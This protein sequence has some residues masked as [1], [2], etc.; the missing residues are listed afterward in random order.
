MPVRLALEPDPRAPLGAS[1]CTQGLRFGVWAPSATRVELCL[2]DPE[3]TEEIARADLHRARHGR[4]CGLWPQGQAGQV[5]GLRAHGPW[6]PAR[7]QRF[8]PNKLLLDPYAREVVGDYRGDPA[9]NGHRADDPLAPDLRDNARIAL[10][11]RA[12][13]DPPAAARPA[14]RADDEVV[15]YEVHVKAATH[16]LAGVPPALRGTYAGLAHPAFVEHLRHLG[17]TTLSLL[18]VAHRVDESRLLSLGL[19]NHWGYNPIAF[20]A[21]ERRYWSGRPGTTPTSE[22]REMVRSLH[23]AGLEVVLDVVFNHTGETDEFGPTLSLRGLGNAESYHL[24]P[25]DPARYENWTG[26]GHALRLD[27]PQGVQ[28]VVDALRHW[29]EV[30]GVDGFRFDLATT[31]A[32]DARGFA[33]NAGLFAAMQADPVLRSVRWIAEPWDIGPGGYRLGQFP[34]GW[35]EWNDRY[36]DTVRAYWLTGGATRGALAQVLAGSDGS[37][38]ASGRDALSSVNFV[39]AHDGFNLRDLVSYGQRHN[40]A[41]GEGNRD[42]HAH[43]LS[44]NAGVEGE[45]DDPSVRETRSRLQHALVATLALSQGT[46]MLLAGDEIGHTQRGNNNAYCQDN[47]LTWL[48]WEGADTR[49]RDEVAAWLALRRHH[50]LLRATGW[51]CEP[52]PGAAPGQVQA[53]WF[54]A[55]GRALDAVAWNDPADRL[56]V[57]EL[58]RELDGAAQ[59]LLLVFNP[60]AT[61]RRIQLSPPP[62]GRSWRLE[63]CSTQALGDDAQAVDAGLQT[64]DWPARAVG[65][66]RPDDG[67]PTH[68]GR[69]QDEENP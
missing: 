19:S 15:L 6:D 27:T 57:L 5:Y 23:E 65:L 44:W 11:A 24:H 62:T 66:L 51:W 12:L 16:R 56:L 60:Q 26:C 29:V 61:R 14:L 3:G 38:R 34:A 43:N 20:F 1:V 52:G 42:G 28:L 69:H 39:T 10:K 45:T 18:P 9:M 54:D 32:R 53:R 46:P 37:F 36:R 33:A 35:Q 67:A 7:G 49:L 30:G 2:F 8:N 4:W 59:A 40:E 41:N 17:V 13:A 31:L 25:E 64:L 21:P 50:A 47:A 48:D 55:E 63:R 58:T 68:S 22:F